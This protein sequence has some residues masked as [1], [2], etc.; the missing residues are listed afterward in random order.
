MRLVAGAKLVL[1]AAL[2]AAPIAASLIVYHFFP[3]REAA[4]YGELLA[5]QP[6]TTQIGRASCRER[7]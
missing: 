4:N 5:P 6:V 3:P 1:I 2:F 7:V